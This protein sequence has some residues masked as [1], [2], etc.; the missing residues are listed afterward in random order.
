MK[1]AIFSES[2]RIQLS[3]QDGL[4]PSYQKN[5]AALR[6]GYT[7]RNKGFDV[8]QI[9]HFT[10]FTSDE[11]LQILSA[12][13]LTT[14]YA[15]ISTSF[16]VPWV[17]HAGRNFWGDT[18]L[19][20]LLFLLE[21][22]KNINP[23]CK[24]LLGG[25]EI[26]DEKFEKDL[27]D[28]WKIPELAR[29]VDYFVIGGDAGVIITLAS[30]EELAYKEY[31]NGAKTVLG[32]LY[33]NKDFTDAASIPDYSK[34]HVLREEALVTEIANGCIFSCEFCNYGSLGKKKGEFQRSYESIKREFEINYKERGTTLYQ[35]NDN[36]V[37][38][39][40]EKLNMLVN[41][42]DELGIDLRWTGYVRPDIVRDKSYADLLLNSGLIA[43]TFGIESLK[44]ETGPTIG[45][46]TDRDKILK[47]LHLCRDSFKD[48][49]TITATF[50]GGLPY[51][52]EEEL[53]NT[54][55]WTR[56]DEGRHLL[57]LSFFEILY[58]NRHTP[59]DLIKQSR[60][61]PFSVYELS[62]D[63]KGNQSWISPWSTKERT[64]GVI[65]SEYFAHVPPNYGICSSFRLISLHNAGFDVNDIIKKVRARDYI[66]LPN[67]E[68]LYN[69]CKTRLDDYKRGMLLNGRN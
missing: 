58:V 33:S 20:K 62:T 23:K 22:I 44:K 64:L 19:N 63:E 52:T 65:N 57:D 60:N 29:Y 15:L 42:R 27:A 41:I 2:S 59:K 51:E 45:K 28:G 49:V 46:L 31:S 35:F 26:K 47:K 54:I 17:T 36:I 38:D 5:S 37:N 66:N 16:L 40:V 30:G 13:I 67:M 6:L 53:R 11:L 55:I 43:C 61:D 56:S 7:L 50:I 14:D 12:E 39:N 4:I 18:I 25:F 10:Y 21:T 48:N 34:D 32:D 1:V 68:A 3:K 69:G 9:F 24:V 8:K